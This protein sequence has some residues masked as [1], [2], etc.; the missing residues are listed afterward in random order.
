MYLELIIPRKQ[1]LNFKDV[2]YKAER[3]IALIQ[4]KKE[5]IYIGKTLQCCFTM[6][7]KHI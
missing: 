7:S 6:K 4:G 1:K 3:S 5:T 2:Q